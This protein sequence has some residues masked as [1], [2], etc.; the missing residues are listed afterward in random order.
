MITLCL[1]LADYAAFVVDN[2]DAIY[3]HYRTLEHAYQAA[4]YGRMMLGGGDAPL[5]N[6]MIVEGC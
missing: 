5:V 6:V 2:S 4:L 1:T 3:A